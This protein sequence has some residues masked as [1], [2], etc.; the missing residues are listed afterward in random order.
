MSVS[1]WWYKSETEHRSLQWKSPESP[2]LKCANVK[3]R[4]QNYAYLLVPITD[5]FFQNTCEQ[6][7]L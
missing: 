5:M 1:I 4:H 7:I 6:S 3:V 2:G